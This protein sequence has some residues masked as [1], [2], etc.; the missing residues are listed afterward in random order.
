VINNIAGLGTVF[1]KDSWL[2][3]V[4]KFLY[5]IAFSQSRLVFFQNPDDLK[6]FL[7]LNLVS[8]TQAG[9]L[10]GSG[11]DLNKF[12]Q[13]P[14]PCLQIATDTQI[15]YQ[16]SFVFL[17]VAR[18]LKEKGIEEYVQSARM[19]KVTHPHT[20]FALL[21][22][23]DSENPNAISTEQLKT[24]VEEGVVN[25]WGTSSDVRVQLTQVDCVVLPSY[26]EGTPRALLEAA[27]MGR[28]IIT[29]DVPGC[30][31]VVRDGINGFL[32]LPKDSKNLAEKMNLMMS[33]SDSQL[34]K[35]AHESRQWAEERFNE[36]LVINQYRKAIDG[37][38]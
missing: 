9:L 13:L 28:P 27:A 22:Y 14:L 31:E 6:L 4:L 25:Y 34:K 19:I 23:M 5:R 29:T 33:M 38:K 11:V 17:L 3:P 12:Q 10:P 8:Q 7:K 20:Q 15:T 21:G 1:I 36:Q 16:R 26:R 2:K 30:R 37:L 18:M 24:W 35:M 32:C